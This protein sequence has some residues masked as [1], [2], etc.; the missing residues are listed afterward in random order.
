MHA[1]IELR[2]LARTLAT[3]LQTIPLACR[4]WWDRHWALV[5]TRTALAS[6]VV[7]LARQHG[8]APRSL[9]TDLLDA[10]DGPSRA[11]RLD[12]LAIRLADRR[13]DLATRVDRL[14]AAGRDHADQTR[15][16]AALGRRLARINAARRPH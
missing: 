16:Y 3:E 5:D 4:S 7:V 6:R 14:I 15:R 11:E 8:P 1:V 2:T 13:Y 9:A 12:S 10:L